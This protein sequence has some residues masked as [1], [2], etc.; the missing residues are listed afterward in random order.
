MGHPLSWL[1][2]ETQGPSTS[3]GMTDSFRVCTRAR[4]PAPH[5][6]FDGDLFRCDIISCSVYNFLTIW[7]RLR[8]DP[9]LLLGMG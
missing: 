2:W 4:A 9:F 3:L 1:G 8:P 7:V 5:G 6:L